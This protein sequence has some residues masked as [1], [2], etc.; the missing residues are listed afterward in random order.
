MKKSAEEMR[1]ARNAASARYRA[2]NPEKARA[3][4]VAWRAR[5]PDYHKQYALGYAQRKLELA[6]A[7]KYPEPLWPQPERCE[8]CNELF[9]HS[10]PARRPCLDHD[11]TTDAF[12]GWPCNGCN[13]TLARAGDSE[14]G[15]QRF[16][17]YLVR[18]RLRS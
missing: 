8:I 1:A 5:N 7:R 2:K 17:D 14:Q 4:Q 13:I 9:D 11:H 6:R 18:A 16:L 12:R 10:I 3:M 15:V